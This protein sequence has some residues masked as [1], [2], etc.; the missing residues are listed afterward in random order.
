ARAHAANEAK[1]IPRS[2]GIVFLDIKYARNS[3]QVL[4]CRGW[5]K[6]H[7]RNLRKGAGSDTG[8]MSDVSKPF[9]ARRLGLAILLLALSSA[10]V[11]HRQAPGRSATPKPAV[12]PRPAAATENWK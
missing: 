7:E 2:P 4:P 5:R 8:R 12:A 10:V 1:R 3:R 9:Q 6:T 11:A